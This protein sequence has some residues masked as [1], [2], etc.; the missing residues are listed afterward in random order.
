MLAGP[1]NPERDAIHNERRQK[2]WKAV[3]ELPV[4]DRQIVLLYLEGLS[5]AEIHAVTG[6]TG[7]KIAMRL[8]RLRR[9]LA[10]LLHQAA[11][12]ETR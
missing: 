8:S 12:E 10:E 11:K 9:R 1:A 7:G 2:L 6:F 3:Q 4:I 5:T